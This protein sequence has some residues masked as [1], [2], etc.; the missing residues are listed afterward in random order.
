MPHEEIFRK[1]NSKNFDNDFFQ[2]WGKTFCPHT[3]QELEN[4]CYNRTDVMS[5]EL[6]QEFKS[7][8][9]NYNDLSL[10]EKQS[11]KQWILKELIEPAWSKGFGIRP[12]WSWENFL[13]KKENAKTYLD[14]GPC[15]GIHSNILYK[16]F[17]KANFDFYS[18]D[19]LPCY[20]ELQTIFGINASYFDA[21]RT[22]LSNLYK[23]DFFDLIMFAEVLEHLT[24]EQGE[25]IL[26]DISKIISSTGKLMLSFPVDA[27]PLNQEPFGHIYQ[28]NVEQVSKLL[29]KLNLRSQEYVKLWS[30]K[31]YQHVIIASKTEI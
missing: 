20:L 29:F 3:N 11:I 16:E 28:P 27:R 21:D 8:I 26:V 9:E 10:L 18:A 7:F 13:S 14:I 23:G 15:H 1:L 12:K 30:G 5:K 4:Y 6:E 17:Y 31:T 2:K 22:S 19:I 24:P 25:Q